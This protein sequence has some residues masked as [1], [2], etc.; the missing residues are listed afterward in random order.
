[1]QENYLA[2]SLVISDGAVATMCLKG[3]VSQ[4]GKRSCQVLPRHRR[5]TK[6]TQEAS[7]REETWSN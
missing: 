7:D 3:R 6:V 2:C 5:E 1:M 4:A